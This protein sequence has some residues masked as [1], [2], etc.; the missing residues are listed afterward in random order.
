MKNV[1]IIDDE[2][3]FRESLAEALADYAKEFRTL[4]ASDGREALAILGR[5]PVDVLV[6]DL[7]MP[8]TDGFAVLAHVARENPDLPIIVM[9]AYGTS[10][11]RERLSSFGILACLDKPIDFGELVDQVGRGLRLG[12]EGRIRGI[13]LPAFL[14]LLELE[15]KTCTLRV[16]ADDRVG[17]LYFRDGILIDADTGT[18]EGE[19]AAY[20]IATWATSEIEIDAVCPRTERR[21]KRSLNAILMDAFR[22][23]DEVNNGARP[24]AIED[25][26]RYQPPGGNQA[27]T[28]PAQY[29]D[30]T[31]REMTMTKTQETLTKL[32]DLEGV[33]VCCLVGRDGFMLDSVTRGNVDP[34]MIAAIAAS[35]FGA[36]E[37]MGRQLEKG[38][39][40][41]TIS[42]YGSGPVLLSPVGELG[43]VVVVAE[44]GSNLG[45][46]RL[47]VKRLAGELAGGLS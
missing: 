6:T 23:L 21:V 9:T 18:A 44:S 35:G 4:V 8:N 42:E 43:V 16:V 45:L 13:R 17:H 10:E 47:H 7:R 30:P 3:T 37:A 24:V 2:A 38:S 14:Q 25:P 15:R 34:E 5:T 11:V 31:G 36:S 27:S 39:L 1:L 33:T 29:G 28:G 22:I 40:A 20:D 26:G 12:G 19:A 41:I 32:A 46:I